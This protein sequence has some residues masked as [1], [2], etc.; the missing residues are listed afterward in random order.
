MIDN[1]SPPLPQYLVYFDLQR[2]IETSPDD[3]D[4]FRFLQALL[5]RLE[6]NFTAHADGVPDV[7]R[8]FFERQL[9]RLN[10][11]ARDVASGKLRPPPRRGRPRKTARNAV[12]VETIKLLKKHC[13]LPYT[14]THRGPGAFSVVADK[15]ELSLGYVEEEIWGKKT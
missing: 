5:K 3:L 10:S 11:W 13:G 7:L 8:P 14:D 1:L 9:E 2:V 4:A 12:I 6:P 15:L